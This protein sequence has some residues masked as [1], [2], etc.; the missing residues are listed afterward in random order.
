MP[1][2]VFWSASARRW[3]IFNQQASDPPPPI[4]AGASFNVFVDEAQIDREC[5]DALF[6]DGFD[7][8]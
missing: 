4:A 3:A 2:G 6:T 5:A 1:I 8:F 7:G